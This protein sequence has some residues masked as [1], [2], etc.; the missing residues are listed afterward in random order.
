MQRWGGCVR[1][2]GLL[3]G[4]GRGG[5]CGGWRHG[6]KPTVLRHACGEGRLRAGSLEVVSAPIV[7]VIGGGQLARMMQEE[8]SALGIHLR[9]L[10][11]AADGST[12]QV[13][14]DAFVGA[15][16]DE[17]AVRAVVAG[18]GTQGPGGEP[19]AV[20]TFEHEHQDASLLERLQAESVSVQP[21]PQALELAPG[22]ALRAVPAPG[23]S[24]GSTLF[25]FEARLADNAL[26]YEAEVI[27]DD[28]AVADEEHTYLM[29]LDGD[30]IFK[31]S[32]G[33]TDL[34][35]GDQVQMLATLRFLANAVD[36]ATILLPGHGAVTTMEHEHH[37]NPYLA[38]A[39][40]RGGD[41]KA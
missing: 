1:G 6:L 12:G 19:A 27:D 13:T 17:A 28:P 38:E 23:H 15:A 7:A 20:V 5:L 16:D 14:P 9:A 3:G 39:K 35:G 40:I 31:G 26:L 34:P 41:L 4:G 8:A 25:F 37:G 11:E 29:A 32:V 30:V 10:V 22:I 24:E 36:P 18:D 33:R 21:T 2:E